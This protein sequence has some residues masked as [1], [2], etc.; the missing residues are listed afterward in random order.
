MKTAGFILFVLVGLLGSFVSIY[1]LWSPYLNTSNTEIIAGDY[2]TEVVDTSLAPTS[3]PTP[4]EVPTPTTF[5]G[6]DG[7]PYHR[8]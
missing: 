7:I 4:T 8:Y 1:Y 6:P 2:N 3:F 5:F